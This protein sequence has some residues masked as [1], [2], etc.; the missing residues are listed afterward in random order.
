MRLDFVPSNMQS[1]TMGSALSIAIVAVLGYLLWI[2]QSDSNKQQTPAFEY[3]AITDLSPAYDINRIANSSLFTRSAPVNQTP[4]TQTVKYTE[5]QSQ[6]SKP[7]LELLGIVYT[8]SN[9]GV[10][11]L[12]HGGIT[13]S[14]KNGEA[15]L[16][17]DSLELVSVKPNGIEI[18]YQGFTAFYELPEQY[19]NQSSPKKQFQRDPIRSQPS[20]RSQ[21]P[22]RIAKSRPQFNQGTIPFED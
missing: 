19:S 3:S 13:A 17:D 22:S 6:P 12:N 2:L 4:N 15:L 7:D 16:S 21:N 10:A 1:I 20:I 11:V 9:T 14:Y 18:S 5:T 8:G